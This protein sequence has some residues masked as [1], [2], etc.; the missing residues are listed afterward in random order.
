MTALS[1]QMCRSTEHV[2]TMDSMIRTLMLQQTVC[3]IGIA[4]THVHCVGLSRDD[5]API[6]P[7]FGDVWVSRIQGRYGPR[8][9]Q[10]M[11]SAYSARIS[12][13]KI[14]RHDI[15]WVYT[16]RHRPFAFFSIQIL[17]AGLSNCGNSVTVSYFLLLHEKMQ[18]EDAAQECSAWATVH[19]GT[20][21]EEARIVEGLRGY[22]HLTNWFGLNMQPD[23]YYLPINRETRVPI[24]D[25]VEYQR[26]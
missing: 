17:V 11:Y 26:L 3:K 2:S 14:V 13:K 4:L 10:I 25:K 8:S 16:L 1:E 24:F 23:P 21:Q 18:F 9:W 12:N 20:A 15:C 7:V 22:C 6:I 19:N 5:S